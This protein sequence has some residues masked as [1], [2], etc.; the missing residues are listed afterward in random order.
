MKKVNYL[1]LGAV[2]LA[3]IS[4]FLPWIEVSVAGSTSDLTEGFQHITV[5]GISMGYGIFGLLVTLIGGY[6]AFKEFK[7]TFLAGIAGFI[8]GYGYLHEWFGAATHD[9]G[10]YGDV[11]SK[12]II[13]F[14]FGIYLFLLASLA[15]IVFTLKNYK[16]KK[17]E[18]VP[19]TVPDNSE[20]QQAAF[21]TRNAAASPVY[22]PSKIQTMSTSS[23]ETPTGPVSTETPKAPEQAAETAAEQPATAPAETEQA[24]ETPIVTE[25]PTAAP[26]V[27]EPAKPTA[28]AQPT[29]APKAQVIPEPAPVYQAPRAS[30][31]PQQAYVEP[32]KKKSSTIWIFVT[33]LMIALIGAGVFFIT[34]SSS[35]KS[36]D[37]NEQSVNDEKA[38]L[39]I[40][41]NEVNQDVSDKKYD[42]A[43]LKINS[44]NWL[45]EPDANKGYVDRYNSQREDLRN[46]IEQLKTNQGLEDQRQATEKA[47]EASQPAQTSD[48]IHN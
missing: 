40:I 4:I 27:T 16:S 44:I 5:R 19:P 8:D 45:Y 9:S 46:T 28:S 47:N 36:K 29:E 24:T 18:T 3:V 26:T 39:Q 23:S 2:A 21:T 15:F 20:H 31:A 11:T 48:S 38:R 25:Q 7:W 14:K 1:A 10:N 34:S 22:Q 42:D 32:E 6:M 17:T 30:A 13:D 43:L 41:V 12:G 35:Q 33:I 37:K